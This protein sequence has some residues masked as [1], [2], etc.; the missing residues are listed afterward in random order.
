MLVIIGIVLIIF[1]FIASRQLY[2][3]NQL[4][5]NEGCLTVLKRILGIFPKVNLNL[6]VRTYYVRYLMM[7]TCVEGHSLGTATGPAA[8]RS[9]SRRRDADARCYRRRRQ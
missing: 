6:K 1:I 8:G 2:K 4:D 5:E 9:A 7:C 3:E